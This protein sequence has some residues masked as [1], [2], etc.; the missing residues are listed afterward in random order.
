MKNIHDAGL[1]LAQN[2][3]EIQNM[4]KKTA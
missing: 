1:V 4:T 2:S 3:Y